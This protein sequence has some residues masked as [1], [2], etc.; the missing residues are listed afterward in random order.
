MGKMYTVHRYVGNGVD[1]IQKVAAQISLSE[2]Y[3]VVLVGWQSP[4]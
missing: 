4:P 2:S 3:M 1:K